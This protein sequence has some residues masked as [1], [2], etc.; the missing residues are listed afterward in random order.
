MPILP[1][2]AEWYDEEFEKT[3]RLF[4]DQVRSGSFHLVTS[5]VVEAEMGAA[6]I[7]VQQ[8]FD[9]MLPLCDIV[10]ISR[11]ALKLQEAYLKSEIVTPKWEADALHVALA[12]V[13][14]CALIVSWNF[15]HIVHF[16]KIPLYNAVNVLTGYREIAIF[17]PL[18]VVKYE[19]KDV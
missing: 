2:S 3:S 12:T 8:F 5:A 18:E 13:S 10:P 4:F 19:D 9:D 14:E 1:C 15:R 16:E 11:E 17:S 7:E 6:P